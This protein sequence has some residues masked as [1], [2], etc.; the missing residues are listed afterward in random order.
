[1]AGFTQPVYKTVCV[2]VPEGI[3]LCETADLHSGR[4]F[5]HQ[6]AVGE[7]SKGLQ[8]ALTAITIV[9]LWQLPHLGRGT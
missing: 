3:F 5:M 1:M 4:N 2:K 8:C 6:Q 7:I 9:A